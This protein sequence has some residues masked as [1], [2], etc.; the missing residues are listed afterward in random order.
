MFTGYNHWWLIPL[1]SCHLGAL[2]G[3]GL[4]VVMIELHWPPETPHQDDIHDQHHNEDNQ[5]VVDEDKQPS[6]A[7][8]GIGSNFL[9]VSRNKASNNGS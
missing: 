7:K 6:L 2:L 5:A 9:N 4:Y 3:A 8:P 1:V